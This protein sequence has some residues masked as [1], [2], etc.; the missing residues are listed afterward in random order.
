MEVEEYI[1]KAFGFYDKD[2]SDE[3]LERMNI[4]IQYS[5]LFEEYKQDK[6]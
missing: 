1:K 5:F 3:T 2:L 6:V 4:L